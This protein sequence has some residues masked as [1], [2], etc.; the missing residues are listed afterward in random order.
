M[1]VLSYLFNIPISAGF[2]LLDNAITR[3]IAKYMS[4][5]FL[6]LVVQVMVI[7]IVLVV[8]AIYLSLFYK[9]RKY[10]YT[11]R[12]QKYLEPLI[13]EIL[14]EE[15]GDLPV[16]ERRI[17]R[18]LNNSVA[19]Q[20]AIDELI[21]CKKNFSGSVS[22][23]IVALYV[24]LGLKKQSL[25]KLA[26]DKWYIKARGIQELYMMDQKDLLKTIYSNTNSKN[27]FVRMEAQTG[28]INLAGFA[29][30]RFLDV[31]SYPL[32]EWQ[33]LKLLEQLKLY[34]EREG[35]SENIPKWLQ[36]K[37]DTVV[38]F[39]LKLADEYQQ[40][41]VRD[42]VVGCLDHTDHSVRRQAIKTLLRLEDEETPAILLAYFKEEPFVNQAFILD[43]LRT[44]ATGKETDFLIDLLDHPNDTIKLK[45]AVILAECSDEGL[46]ILEKRGMEQP[47]PY[48]RI[49]RHVKTVK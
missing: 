16:I 34:H 3:A 44:L 36:S 43:A 42:Y 31:I 37:N 30:L 26:N 27:A 22:A 33:Q 28:V 47:E 10:F 13:S 29:G 1:T 32:T 39:A 46:G 9:K 14:M 17:F 5:D 4:T 41:G 38:I 35:L 20:Y 23:S 7:A 15:S 48:E 11:K 49:Y 18:I 25:Q 19:R 40:F 12:I 6:L 45:A 8:F 21:R 2:V 24:Q